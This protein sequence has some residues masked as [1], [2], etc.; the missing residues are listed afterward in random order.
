MNENP[1]YWKHTLTRFGH[2]KDH[3]IVDPLA[4]R[5]GVPVLGEPCPAEVRVPLRAVLRQ[6]F[7]AGNRQAPLVE[8][9]ADVEGWKNT[10]PE[11]IPPERV[12]V[13]VPVR[14]AHEVLRLCFECLMEHTPGMSDRAEVTFAFPSATADAAAVDELLRRYTGPTWQTPRTAAPQSFAENVNLAASCSRSDFIVLLNSDAYVAPGWL[15]ALLAPF[16]DRDVVAVGPMGT[17]VSGHQ[18]IEKDEPIGIAW[19]GPAGVAAYVAEWQQRRRATR[20]RDGKAW[21]EPWYDARRLV[22]FCM[23]I[24]RSAWDRVGGM[25]ERFAN[26]FCDDDLSLRLSLVGKCVVVPRLLVPHEGQASFRETP[27]WAASYNRTLEANRMRFVRKWAW[28][29]KDWHAWC[30]ANGWR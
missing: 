6:A 20:L 16:E 28:L 13:I 17:N 2:W 29:F 24:R 10:A 15:D 4:P 1:L 14:G 30:D 3:P 26:A 18:A 21:P 5:A 12:S 9:L 25:D 23:A 27:D 19:D 11:F 7:L 22:G 8:A